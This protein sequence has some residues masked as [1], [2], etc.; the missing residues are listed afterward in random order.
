MK[1]RARRRT[2]TMASIQ[3]KKGHM[4]RRKLQ[5]IKEHKAYVKTKR[6]VVHELGR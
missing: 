6:L 2:E 5:K 4:K 1:S 3:G